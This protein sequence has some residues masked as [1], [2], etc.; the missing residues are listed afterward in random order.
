MSDENK[1]VWKRDN[2]LEWAPRWVGYLNGTQVAT[3]AVNASPGYW[4]HYT[5]TSFGHSEAQPTFKE[6]K[7]EVQFEAD[8]RAAERAKEDAEIAGESARRERGEVI[9]AQTKRVIFNVAL[10]LPVGSDPSE[11]ATFIAQALEEDGFDVYTSTVAE[12]V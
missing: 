4:N 10:N 7:R 2:E 6:F 3:A 12:E 1:V 8:R 9:P 5:G 11:I